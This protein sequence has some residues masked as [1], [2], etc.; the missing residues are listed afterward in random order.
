MKV[1]CLCY[2]LVFPFQ[3]RKEKLGD[4]ITALH[5]LVS[6][7]GKVCIMH[8]VCISSYYTCIS[9][10]NTSGR[11]VTYMYEVS[12]NSIHSLK[13]LYIHF[14]SEQQV[15]VLFF[16]FLKNIY[17]QPLGSP[18]NAPTQHLLNATIYLL[19]RKYII[20]KC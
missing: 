9:H 3:V 13:L 12:I 19:N 4:R 18:S 11:N 7:F 5:Q 6:P 14:V 8:Y 20:I 15:P 2:L 16:S 17:R 1:Q 10:I